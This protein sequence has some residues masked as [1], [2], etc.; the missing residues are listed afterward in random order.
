LIA[1][2]TFLNSVDAPE[3]FGLPHGPEFFIEQG[4]YQWRNCVIFTGNCLA[5]LIKGDVDVHGLF[6]TPVALNLPNETMRMIRAQAG[7][8]GS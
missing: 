8:F 4:Q 7:H 5:A 3:S 6:K 2:N 1:F